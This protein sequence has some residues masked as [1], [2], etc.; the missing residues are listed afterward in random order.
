MGVGQSIKAFLFLMLVLTWAMSWRNSIYISLSGQILSL[1][2]S[3]G[4]KNY[5]IELLVELVVKLVLEVG[6]LMGDCRSISHHI[7]VVKGQIHEVF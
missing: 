2:V 6:I 5:H 1:Y 4:V 7:V 3:F